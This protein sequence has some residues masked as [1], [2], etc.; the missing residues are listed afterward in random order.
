VL[1]GRADAHVRESNNFGF[2]AQPKESC[3]IKWAPTWRSALVSVLIMGSIVTLTP[4]SAAG[5]I[6]LVPFPDLLER[7]KTVTSA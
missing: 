1:H 5:E 4:V 6:R 2:V 7:E 3:G